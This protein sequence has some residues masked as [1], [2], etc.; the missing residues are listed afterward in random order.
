M[1]GR[2]VKYTKSASAI[3]HD[4]VRTCGFGTHNE[5]VSRTGKIYGKVI[6]DGKMIDESEMVDWKVESVSS[7]RIS[8]RDGYGEIWHY[9]RCQ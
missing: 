9:D 6:F 2:W 4:I 5:F 3:H 1:A 7:S 8:F